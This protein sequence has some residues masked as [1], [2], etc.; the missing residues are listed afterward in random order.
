MFFGGEGVNGFL[1]AQ[2]FFGEFN[3]F[4]LFLNIFGFF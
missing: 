1:G 2:T 4:G 3:G